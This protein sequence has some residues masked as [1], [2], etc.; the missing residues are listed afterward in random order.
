MITGNQLVVVLA[1]FG[2][3][4]TKFSALKDLCEVRKHNAYV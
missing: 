1:F 3:Q 4:L 2:L